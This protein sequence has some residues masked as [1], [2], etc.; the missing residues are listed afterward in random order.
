MGQCGQVVRVLDLKSGGPMR[1][2]KVL[3]L[4]Q[5]RNH[6]RELAS[7]CTLIDNNIFRF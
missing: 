4:T 6:F 2:S 5:H 3:A 7:T 1:L